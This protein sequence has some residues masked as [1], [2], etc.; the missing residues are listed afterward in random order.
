MAYRA[1]EPIIEDELEIDND[2]LRFYYRVIQALTENRLDVIDDDLLQKLVEVRLAMDLLMEKKPEWFY[3]RLRTYF[4]WMTIS[5]IANLCNARTVTAIFIR[6]YLSMIVWLMLIFN[7]DRDKAQ[8]CLLFLTYMRLKP[9]VY[10]YYGKTRFIFLML[11]SVDN[12]TLH[13]CGRS[14]IEPCIV[15]NCIL[16]SRKLENTILSNKI[17]LQWNSCWPMKKD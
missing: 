6:S 5:I 14:N 17:L 8:R 13:E 3:I 9:H 7:H 1:I 16:P 11:R 4:V 10:C 12:E 15:H 2:L